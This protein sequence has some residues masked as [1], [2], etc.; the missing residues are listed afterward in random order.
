MI[1][2][3]VDVKVAAELTGESER[4]VR[5]KAAEN[6]YTSRSIL[7]AGV[8]KG[9]LK[10]QVLVSSLPAEA[11]I[12]FIEKYGADQEVSAT[13]VD[14]V[15]DI[16]M[17]A[18]KEK[19]GEEGMKEFVKK[20]ELVQKALEI[21]ATAK[22]NKTILWEELAKD[23]GVS[24]RNLDRWIKGF[25]EFGAKSLMRKVERS[26]K[27]KTRSTCYAAKVMLFEKWLNK[28]KRKKTKV[29]KMVIEYAESEGAKACENCIFREGTDARIKAEDSGMDLPICNEPVKEGLIVSTSPATISRILDAA[30]SEE[31]YTYA[32][33][34][35]KA[36]EAKFMHKAT[37]DKPKLINEVWFGDHHV[38]DVFIKDKDEK[39]V[40]PWLT[41]CYDAASGCIVGWCL[42]TN[43]N[44][45][46]IAEA[47]VYGI[48][49]KK[50]FPFWGPPLIVYTDNGKDYRSHAFEGGSIVD[51]SFGTGMPFHV[52]TVGILKSLGI[53]NTHAKA[54]HG[55]AKPIER[56]FGTFADQYVRE[57]PGWCGNN[58]EERPEGFEKD[59]KK[60]AQQDKLFTMD[61][62]RDWFINV[63][64]EYH[65]TPHSGYGGNKPIDI[66]LSG[67]KARTDKPSMAILSLLKMEV[68]ERTITT[69]GITFDKKLYWHKELSDRHLI[70]EKVQI[71]YN[72]ENKDT[73]L[74][75]HQGKFICA[76]NM[77]ENLKMVREDEEKIAEHVGNQKRQ[78]REVKER[79]AELLGKPAPK[80]PKK[81]TSNM[82]TGDMVENDKGNI[83]SIEHE[84][85]MKAYKEAVDGKKKKKSTEEA[86][87]VDKKYLETGEEIL[88]KVMNK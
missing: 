66:Y 84:K 11:Q 41:A 18:Y 80:Q 12:K 25:K 26:N 49:D 3:Y 44:S 67:E 69:Q 81:S 56:W 32:V 34:G 31:V 53:E 58:P 46:T 29:L 79:I 9:G 70:N 85:A 36:W 86:G 10:L 72:K 13:A 7:D 82:M 35:R 57:L 77:K 15:I 87:I 30:I 54:Y 51:K 27:G 42:S 20:Y 4:S 88:K 63:L 23:N 24:K 62:L 39:I 43:P 65:N 47:L 16:D 48:S 45:Q 50:D 38:L 52:D 19:F 59:L 74:V 68:E 78:E 75:I 14:E 83:T 5:R 61:E 71:R 64:N 60:L 76:A 73:I 2:S 1:D 37:R 22:G 40:K 6:K 17:A 8:G 28:A 21:E 55:W 33:Y